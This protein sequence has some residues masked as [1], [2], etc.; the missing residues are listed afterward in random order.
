MR[1]SEQLPLYFAEQLPRL[2]IAHPSFKFIGLKITQEESQTA[3]HLIYLEKE[4]VSDELP[5]RALLTVA[6][7]NAKSDE[8]EFFLEALTAER[9]IEK[10]HYFDDVGSFVFF[11]IPRSV[12]MDTVNM[13]PQPMFCKLFPELGEFAANASPDELLKLEERSV[14]LLARLVERLNISSSNSCVKKAY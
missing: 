7:W 2:L 4:D 10:L 3:L 6:E 13:Y 14:S 8:E 11:K 5:F 9:L 1:N 12:T